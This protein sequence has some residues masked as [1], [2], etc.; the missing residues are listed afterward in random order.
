MQNVNLSIIIPCYN[1]EKTIKK[2]LETIN[3]QYLN[4][5]IRSFEVILVDDGSKTKISNIVDEDDYPFN[6][7]IVRLESNCGLSVARNIGV[8]ISKGDILIFIDSDIILD[9]N[10]IKE[11]L[12]RN[13]IIQNAIF[14][15]FKENVKF[16]DKRISYQNIK[17]GINPPDYSRDLRIY[18]K[19]KKNAVGSYCVR[20]N[21]EIEILEATNYFKSF[22]G[23]RCFG[24]YDLSCMVTGHNFSIRK[25]TLLKASAFTHEISGWGMEDVYL[26]LKIINSGNFIIPVLST[27]VYHIDHKPRSG[28]NEKKIKEYK[29]NTK[30]INTLL[31]KEIFD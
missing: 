28:S 29:K 9:K 12:V 15:S 3:Y 30:Y 18:K 6:M 16:E 10:Y 2:V 11:H 20:K 27:G 8:N 14:V 21:M 5:N 19:V 17:R 22:Y 25:S 31:D 7:K 23:S 4:L 24:V 26:G 1:T 13:M